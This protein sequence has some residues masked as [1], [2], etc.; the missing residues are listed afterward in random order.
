RWAPRKSCS[1]SRPVIILRGA[2]AP[3]IWVARASLVKMRQA[4]PAGPS[5]IWRGAALASAD[6]VAS[7]TGASREMGRKAARWFSCRAA[8]TKARSSAFAGS[9][10]VSCDVDACWFAPVAL[11]P[12]AATPFAPLEAGGLRWACGG[13]GELVAPDDDTL[14]PGA[15]TPWG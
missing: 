7:A 6:T 1:A 13:V 12:G 9:I 11:T 10:V 5:R 14:I 2:L 4:S 8:L 15:A 3:M